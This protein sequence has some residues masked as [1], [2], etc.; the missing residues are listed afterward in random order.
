[1]KI[2]AVLLSGI[3][4]VFS[5]LCSA[6]GLTFMNGSFE[7]GTDPGANFITLTG[8]SSSINGWTVDPGGSID[9]IGGLWNASDGSRS[10]DM[11]GNSPGSIRQTFDTIPGATY[12]ILFDMAAN[13]FD[14]EIIKDLRASIDG[15]ISNDYSFD[16]S[17]TT[18]DSMGWIEQS[19]QF[20]AS[21]NSSTLIFESLESSLPFSPSS[22]GPALDNVRVNMINIPASKKGNTPTPEPT[23]MLMFGSGIICLAGFRRRL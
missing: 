16:R 6:H 4:L 1:M 22:W 10:L 20:I 14:G 12:E 18:W 9:Y 13:P 8:P 7:M 23:T 11:D 17:G 5:L 19:F 2:I 15:V 21:T 3:G